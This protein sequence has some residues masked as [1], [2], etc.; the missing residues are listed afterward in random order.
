MRTLRG[1]AAALLAL[2]TVIHAAP[3]RAQDDDDIEEDAP[4]QNGVVVQREVFVLNEMQFN[5]WLYNNGE[6]DDVART[7]LRT[8]LTLQIDELARACRLTDA[9]REKLRLAGQGDL[10]RFFG[11]VAIKRKELQDKE[12]DQNKINDIFQ[13]LRPLQTA[14]NAGILEENS[15]FAKT[16]ATT[17]DPDQRATYEAAERERRRFRYQARVELIV[18]RLGRTLG[19]TSQQHR[20]LVDLIVAETKLPRKSGQY[21]QYIVMVQA[22][23]LPKEKLT[24]ILDEAQMR[25]FEQHLNQARGIEQFLKQNGYLDDDDGP[26]E[27]EVNAAPKQLGDE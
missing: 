10:A 4:P 14:Y 5:H 19:L 1:W 3:A 21:D 6:G 8:H 13:Q 20:K 12:Y 11:R 24:A 7:K 16:I 22:R 26:Q 17:L 27:R 23:K 15:L 25:V 18:L 2:S 9:Q